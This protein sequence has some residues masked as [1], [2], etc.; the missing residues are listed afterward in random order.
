[1]SETGTVLIAGASGLV[2]LAAVERFL[3][4][5]CDVIAVSRRE[6]EVRGK[7]NWR[8][9]DLD[10][11][12]PAACQAAA[13]GFA[14]VAYVVYAAVFGL[15]TNLQARRI[16][17]SNKTIEEHKA[18]LEHAR[19]AAE[20][21]SRDR[22]VALERQTTIGEILRVINSSPTDYRPVCEAIVRGIVRL[23]DGGAMSAVYRLVDGRVDI[24]AQ[25]NFPAEALAQVD[26]AYPAPLDSP[27]TPVRA[28]RERSILHSADA[29]TDPEVAEISRRL[30]VPSGTVRWRSAATLRAGT[31]SR[32]SSPRRSTAS[33]GWTSSSRTP[34]SAPGAASSRRPSS[35]GR[36]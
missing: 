22:G 23:C 10:L 21:Q 35:T 31:S 8:H 32:G 12:D 30:G 5:G 27:L 2:G 33:G 29:Q 14:D 19:E 9:V 6:P 13:A 15:Q 4:D 18:A 7:G 24:V 3:E 36:P 26:V 11:R 20:R 25:Y 17:Q 1:M 16:I 28:I 34:G